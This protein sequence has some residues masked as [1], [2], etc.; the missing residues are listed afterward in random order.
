MALEVV[1][2][3]HLSTRAHPLRTALGAL[4][5]GSGVATVALAISALDGV[6]RFARE[7]AA[8]SFGAD[9]FQVSRIAAT[10]LSR[11]ERVEKQRRNP[12]LAAS[13]LRFLERHADAR[14]VYAPTAQRVADVS[15]GGREFERAAV[16]G[17]VASLAGIRD[18]ELGAGRFLSPADQARAAQVAVLGADVAD[19]LFPGRDPLARVFRMGGRGFHVIGV[20]TRQG[21][22]AGS[23]QDRYVFVPLAAFER[24]FG[25]PASLDLLARA[26][27]DTGTP[28]AE[29]RAR[30]SLRAR[31]QLRPGVP[32]NFD[33]LSPDAARSFVLRLSERVG[34]AAAPIAAMALLAAIV[35]VANTTLVSVTE[36][37]REIGVKRALGATRR[38]V[39]LETLAESSL[40]ALQGGVGGVAVVALVVAALEPVLPVPLEVRS[41]T[42]ALGVGA[43]F[44]SGLLAGLYPARIASR[45][46]VVQALRSE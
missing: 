34:A 16:T 4:A 7:S 38:Q 46:D 21:S 20:Q 41:G 10:G 31:R 27:G 22:I 11:R 35:V 23:S 32:D 40:V 19:A 26:D 28:A 6:E 25:R 5:V 43:A 29:D 8:R 3:A 12:P 45:V 44:A 36:R 13:E 9:T 39:L 18:L 14:V 17:T 24:V 37:T 2:Q 42:L 1:R 30:A 15:A 33:I